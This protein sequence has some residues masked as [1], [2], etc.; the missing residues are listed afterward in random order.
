MKFFSRGKG[1]NRTV[2]PITPSKG[3]PLVLPRRVIKPSAQEAFYNKY[4][5]DPII[6]RFSQQF[7]EILPE[8][9][10]PKDFHPEVGMIISTDETVALSPHGVKPKHKA[11][12]GKKSETYSESANITPKMME[13][14]QKI[15]PNEDLPSGPNSDIVRFHNATYDPK[16]IY[17]ALNVLDTKAG[18]ITFSKRVKYY[19]A[20]TPLIMKDSLGNT[21]CIAPKMVGDTPLQQEAAVEMVVDLL[22]TMRGDNS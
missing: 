2:H 17:K 15:G 1:R 14:L 6:F 10:S 16:R 20:F 12:V 8:M 21:I 13:A 22:P 7:N 5:N 9:M 4:R 18:P 19:D 11:F 3:E